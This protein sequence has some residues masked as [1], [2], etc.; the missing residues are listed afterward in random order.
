MPQGQYRLAALSGTD[1]YQLP[2][3]FTAES[4]VSL[5]EGL[6]PRQPLMM[7]QADVNLASTTATAY[8][9]LSPVTATLSLHIEHV[10]NEAQQVSVTLDKLYTRV[11]L[12]GDYLQ[13]ASLTVPCCRQD[14]E[15]QADSLCLFPAQADHTVL[16]LQVTLPEE[17]QHYGYN[18][19]M[20]LETGH[21]YQVQ[22][23][24]NHTEGLSPVIDDQDLTQASTTDTLSVSALPA[25]VPCLWHDH[26]LV[27][28]GKVSEREAH[29][30][31]LSLNEWEEVPSAHN[32]ADPTASVLLAHQY[33]EA[34]AGLGILSGWHVPTQEEAT[35]LLSWYA[36]D[37]VYMLN[38][39]L[40][41]ADMPPVQVMD[42]KGH[43]QRYLCNDGTHTFSL[44]SQ[45]AA[46][47]KAGAKTTYRLRLVKRV[48]LR[49]E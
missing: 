47:S 13:P 45:A 32:E 34:D 2:A 20:R 48:C 16:T 8:L 12:A 30:L 5:A 3:T 41:R 9:P 28:L 36:D 39:L 29:A 42:A 27:Y 38:E 24:L 33:M 22:L 19:P 49:C 10:P 15:W 35:L 23:D 6:L 7:G 4:E 14:L 46:L 18:L 43:P 44:S 37:N 31:L 11:T 17:V 21:A 1:Y 40:D 25:I 26:L